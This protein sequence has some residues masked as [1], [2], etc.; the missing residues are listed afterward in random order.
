MIRVRD[1]V[2]AMDDW[3]PRS[4]AESWDNPGLAAGDPDDPV[5]AVLAALDVTDAALDAAAV[6]GVP[7]IISHHPSIFK[8]LVSLAGSSSSA[9]IVRRAIREGTALFSAH[10]NL[11]RA[12]G[13][14]SHAAAI[15][16]GLFS[17]V[18]LIPHA[19]GMFKFVTYCPPSS[20]DRVREAAGSAGAGVMGEYRLCSFSSRGIGAFLPSEHAR[21]FSGAPGV[22][23]REE[24]DRIE[25]VAPATV[26][27]R[28]VDAVRSVH[29]Y[30]EMAYDLIPLANNDGR[31][32]YGAVGDLEHPVG[33]EEFVR[34]VAQAFGMEYLRVSPSP[35]H[36]IRR[37]AVVG[38][39]GAGYIPDAVRA[40]AD[41]F[42]TGDIGHHAFLDAPDSLL[43]IDASHRATELPVLDAICSYL[44]T[45]FGEELRCSVFPGTAIPAVSHYTLSGCHT[46]PHAGAI[47]TPPGISEDRH[48]G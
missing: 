45:S 48:E 25:M 36:M 19:S 26:I 38:G 11:D 24:E 3:A 7:M 21:P 47:V 8:P 33:P 9:R 5:G 2:K 41:A 15:R 16:L 34:H 27:E 18:P 37:V 1:I 44:A 23:S 30:E 20:T 28:V 43:V 17:I 35:G 12:P 22:L 42:I 14:V 46:I 29:P 32:G 39:S 40:N 13:G 31:C 6:S 4:L 10:T